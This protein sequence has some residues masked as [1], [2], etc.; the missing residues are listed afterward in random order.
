MKKTKIFDFFQLQAQSANVP[1]P[2]CGNLVLKSNLNEHLDSSCPS[3]LLTTIS[4]QNSKQ[5]NG[6]TSKFSSKTA[7]RKSAN[8][9]V[10]GRLCLK[11]QR[12]DKDNKNQ[13]KLK[14]F[15]KE[16]ENEEDDIIIL[17]EKFISPSKGI[18]SGESNLSSCKQ[19]TAQNSAVIN[20]TFTNESNCDFLNSDIETIY[21]EKTAAICSRIIKTSNNKFEIIKEVAEVQVEVD[22][23]DD[24]P[25]KR[26]KSYEKC[27]AD[28][29]NKS[30]NISDLLNK[31]IAEQTC[32]IPLNTDR[33][34]GQ[35]IIE[36]KHEIMPKKE[37][38]EINSCSEMLVETQKFCN[39]SS[40]TAVKSPGISD[41]LN[42]AR[43]L[44]E[45]D[46]VFSELS[47]NNEVEKQSSPKN[48]TP[49]Y[50]AN[51]KQI[52]DTVLNQSDNQ[53]LF[54]DEDMKSVEAFKASSDAAQKLYVR[55]FQRKYKW[56][57][58]N[59]INYPDI[60]QDPQNTLEELVKI[61]LVDSGTSDIDLETALELLS[62]PEAKNLA[63][64]FNF[65]SGKSKAEIKQ[66]IL[67]HCKEH[68]SVFFM[69]GTNGISSM[70]LK[71]VK[72]M[73]S[74]CYRISL[75]PKRTFTRVLMLF[76]LPTLSDDEDEAA[77]GQ[78]QQL[79]TLL[80][81]NKGELVFPDY[82]ITKKTVIFCDR[83]ELIRYEEARQLECDIF[84]AMENKK[85]ELAKELCT[86]A[87]EIF[88]DQCSSTFAKRVSSLP[89][90]LKRYTSFHVYVRC[91]TQGVETLQ[92]LR[93][94]K[95][96]VSL[97]RKLLKQTVFCQ[98]YKGRWYDRL[99]LNLEQHLKQPEKAL[100]A[101]KCGL[102][103]SNVRVGNRYSLLTRALR[104][105][106]SYEETDEFRQQ[107]LKEFAVNEAPK[108]IIKGRL[109]PR[110]I[111]G[112]RN[113]F[114]SSSSNADI[115]DVTILGVEQLAMEH[116]KEN[117]FTEGIHG[118]GSTFIS[119]YALLFWDIIYDGS[120][121][122]IFITPYQT[123]PLDL[124]SETF[125]KSRKDQILNHLKTLRHS[126]NEELKEIVKTTWENHHKEASM[127]NWDLFTNLEHAQGLICCFGCDI[128][129]GICE[130]IA[131]DHRF[132]RSGVPD[133][134]VWNPET[135]SVKIVEVKGP[136]DKLSS[137]QILWLD[138]LIQLGAN[139]E[140]CLVEAVASKKLRKE[141]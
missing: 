131:K 115:D 97:L 41:T 120:I 93:Q 28:N 42:D 68:K 92:R 55:L 116:Y 2:A 84:N 54:N 74:P 86:V 98:D 127:V 29:Q 82:K 58:I 35:I 38:P 52:L 26:L 37:T 138:Y 24:I 7:I 85:F 124:N 81:V 71:K 117:G 56:L 80:Q 69:N 62:L 137:K 65:N 76:S 136:G 109:C 90:F 51:F 79:M 77:G 22:S 83:D 8:K 40:I 20:D 50:I 72:Q 19:D 63:K 123:H 61:G 9:D 21:S 10:S 132:T 27:I 100:E 36:A 33:P 60:T 6:E 45:E 140:V 5:R 95:E 78:Q 53:I 130:R 17:E 31:S 67:K 104:I 139:A 119:I 18:N 4:V 11:R 23:C 88:E 94:Y 102:K 25:A 121:P 110:T 39:E 64:H 73:I 106:K 70:M 108:V 141:T 111:L 12:N 107:I 118:E 47:D 133:L 99:A 91:M 30:S 103:D 105:T 135:L 129:S 32:A 34:V 59:K 75:L 1:C 49:Y 44:L 13:T 3:S 101:I 125:F 134:V 16:R 112:R 14:E 48:H 114:I 15:C 126:T 87:K 43:K 57:R 66:M 96:A 122:D 89:P 46:D 128:L 113:V